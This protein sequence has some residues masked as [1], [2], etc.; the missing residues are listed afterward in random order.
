MLKNVEKKQK[1][2]Y[3]DIEVEFYSGGMILY[4]KL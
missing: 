1:T 3:N 2:V 4:D